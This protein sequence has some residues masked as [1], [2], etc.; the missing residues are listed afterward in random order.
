MIESLTSKK[1]MKVLLFSISVIAGILLYIG[2]FMNI[3]PMFFA[4]ME[5]TEKNILAI[6]IITFTV[7]VLLSIIFNLDTKTDRYTLLALYLLVLVLGLLRPDQQYSAKIGLYAWN[8]FGFISDIQSDNFSLIVMVINLLIFLPMYFL[9]AYTNILKTFMKRLIAFEVFAILIEYLQAQLKVGIF[10]LADIFL[11]NVSFLI[12][13]ILC[14]PV[15][16]IL[17]KRFRNKY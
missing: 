14:L 5:N 4:N 12:G 1:I 9:L 7:Y 8:P 13:Y 3:L 6:F 10:D 11:Y 16:K 15:L 17:R 2:F